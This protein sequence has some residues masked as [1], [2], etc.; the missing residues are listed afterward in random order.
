MKY[1][2]RAGW[3]NGSRTMRV[4]QCV[5][6]LL[7][8]LV[9]GIAQAADSA[10]LQLLPAPDDFFA[11]GEETPN[12]APPEGKVLVFGLFNHPRLSIAGVENI[13]A[14]N[15]DGTPIPLTIE[16]N[17]IFYEF[18]RIVSLRFSFL[19]DAEQADDPETRFTLSWGNDI[20]AK[21]MEVSKIILDPEAR[22]R[23]RR[24]Q[25]GNADLGGEAAQISRIE[26]IADMTAGY[27]FL[28]Y[29][30]P[31]AMIFALLTIRKLYSRRPAE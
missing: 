15:T 11:I 4:H 5:C 10:D 27:H 22:M 7:I 14:L 17:S 25:W 31:M 1:I 16:T 26:V 20:T 12:P 3:K 24:F 13:I 29:L 19:V 8:L 30:L 6:W 2:P 21:N 9:G 23:I 18:D 28:W